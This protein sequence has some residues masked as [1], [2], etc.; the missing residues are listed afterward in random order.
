MQSNNLIKLREFL[1]EIRTCH[2]HGQVKHIIYPLELNDHYAPKNL[3]GASIVFSRGVEI[4]VWK[5]LK[6]YLKH[7]YSTLSFVF[8]ENRRTILIIE[9]RASL[10]SELYKYEQIYSLKVVE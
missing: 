6:N 9:D 10:G 8:P 1:T 3:V 5:I 4:E 7:T 2:K